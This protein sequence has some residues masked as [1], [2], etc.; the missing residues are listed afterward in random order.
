MKLRLDRRQ[1]VADRYCGHERAYT[2]VL[3]HQKCSQVCAEAALERLQPGGGV[4]NFH[5][6]I[7]AFSLPFQTFLPACLF[8]LYSLELEHT[9]VVC[10]PRYDQ[11]VP[12][13]MPRSEVALFLLCLTSQVR[14]V[15]GSFLDFQPLP[16]RIMSNIAKQ[17]RRKAWNPCSILP[18]RLCF[19][20]R[21]LSI[22][23]D[24]SE[25]RRC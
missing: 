1:H 5:S 18:S 15:S 7:G 17:K 23:R 8:V 3:Q 21:V 9:S 19:Y 6:S 12:C 10:L 11:L 4:A 25:P 13:R 16:T 24:T 20:A 22:A 14:H 2:H